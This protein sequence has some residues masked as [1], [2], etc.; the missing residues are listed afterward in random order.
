VGE[1]QGDQAE[2]E[3]EEVSP[4]PKVPQYGDAARIEQIASGLKKEHGTYGAVVQRNDPGRP[5]GAAQPQAQQA[6]IP[7][8]HIGMMQRLGEL[9]VVR[10]QWDALARK[11]PTPWVIGMRTIAEENYQKL[12][13]QLY[14]A[15]PNL[16][17]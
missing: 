10:Q 12:A 3:E 6:Q 14:A 7:P 17:P 11:S 4:V 15:T 1:V 8:E 13:Q 9:E 5:S 16:E 2:E